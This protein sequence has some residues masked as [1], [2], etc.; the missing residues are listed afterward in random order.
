MDVGSKKRDGEP[1]EVPDKIS[2]STEG[3]PLPL[4]NIPA[5]P[6]VKLPDEALGA[7]AQAQELSRGMSAAMGSIQAGY[8][9][10]QDSMAVTREVFKAVRANLPDYA[11]MFRNVY[12]A[13]QRFA[14][15]CKEVTRGIDF[16]AIAGALRPLALKAKR[17]ELLG[18]ANWPMY[19]VDD[20]GVCDGLDMLPSRVT[21]T[22]LKELVANVACANLGSEWLGETRS[23]WEEHAELSSGERGVL[24]RALNRHEKGDYEGC[25]AL[26]MNLFE[27]LVEKYF[28]A[29]MSKLEGER[30]ELF[31]LHA[32]KLGVGLSRKKNGEP[33]ELT[34]VKDKVLVMVVLSENGWY[35]FEHAA[36]YIVGVTFANAMDVDLAA[37]NPLR[38]KICHG[39][40]TEYGTQ[41]HSLKAILVTDIVI[42]Y[43]AAILEGQT[44]DESEDGHQEQ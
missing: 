43:G 28:P 1:N 34:N 24:T 23:R 42:R 4:K 29:G 44:E 40:Q 14:D 6:T 36:E 20:A 19:L 13:L 2:W 30:A 31:D 3:A 8:K 32:K 27:G 21:D 10:M 7:F 39:Q 18:R 17:V 16:D 15:Y 5:L 35:T 12:P 11:L 37:H 33:R 41:E 9:Q 22:E 26:L 38:N 25:V